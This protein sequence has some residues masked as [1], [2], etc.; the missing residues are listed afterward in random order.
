MRKILGAGLAMLV[1]GHA[2]LLHAQNLEW[3][4][5]DLKLNLTGLVTVG[6]A[7]RMQEP[8]IDLLGKLNVPG[9]QDLCT[10]DDCMSLAGDPAPN[11]R[12]VNARG[13]LS[14]ANGDNGNMNYQRGDVIAATS[15]LTPT[16]GLEYGK[17]SAKLRGIFFYDPINNDFDETHNNTRFQP[18]ETRRPGRIAEQ[19]GEG[20][21]LREAYVS[22]IVP[23]AD[24]DVTVTLG[25]QLINWGESSLTLFNTLNV[26]NPPDASVARMPGFQ[27]SEA[28]RPE[29]MISL[30]A[31]LSEKISVEGFYQYGWA[32]VIPDPAGSFFSIND[33][34]GGGEY[35]ILGLGN[36]AEDPD[37]QFQ[38]A[39]LASTISQSTRTAL[40]L[41]RKFG[42]PTDGG[43]YGAQL[44]YYAEN[45]NNGT[46]LGFYALNYHSRLPYLSAIT[47][48]ASCTRDAAV[49]TFVA[50]FVACAGFNSA[51]N[52]LGRE[53]L[54]VDTL[55]PFLDYPED[56]QMYGVSFNTSI[57]DWAVAGEYAYRPNMPLQVH[58]TDVIFAGLSPAFPSEDIPV[59]ADVG[60]IGLDAPFTIP[61]EG[62]AAPDFLSAYRGVKIQPN[63]LLRGYERLP[64]GQLVLSG[65]RTFGASNPLRADQI[66]LLVEAG[67]TH[68]EDLPP[69]NVLQFEGTGERTHLSPGA[70]G[71]GAPNGQP[72]SGRI[73]PTQQTQGFATDTSWGYR[74]L[75]R[76]TYN[77]V[78]RGINLYPT[79]VLFH[80]ISG[81]SPSTIDNYVKDRKI[82][83]GVLEAEFTPDL[84]AGIQYMLFTGAGK[85]NLRSD[86]DN[87]SLNLRYSF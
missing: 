35:F 48:D 30:G 33:V 13:S 40:V 23:I 62:H 49:N 10:A 37:R 21:K 3:S 18:A 14:G 80:D 69:L 25:N 47:A 76:F 11:Q 19:F 77:D 34:A 43:Q 41:D 20:A 79:F 46:E 17:F 61:G 2:Q 78:Y 29:P 1:C 72:D 45:L 67:V 24:T 50:A 52:P 86:R 66:I 16:L 54:P 7:W 36:F 39:G 32:P 42:Y 26:I 81:I 73:N 9:Q 6:A 15:K 74:S 53:P 55:R 12:L 8:N 75:V 64:V 59:P 51:I 63:Q 60:L 83:V 82:L 5:G 22:T 44:K 27:L 57:S 38:P 85:N 87:L 31:E 68:V 71:T 65:L 70:D 28:L 56:I 4:A 84:V 58:L